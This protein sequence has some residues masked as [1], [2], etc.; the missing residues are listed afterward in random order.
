LTFE[1]LYQISIAEASP[2]LSI[3]VKTQIIIIVNLIPKL[4]NTNKMV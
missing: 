4:N 2:K 3:P 1:G